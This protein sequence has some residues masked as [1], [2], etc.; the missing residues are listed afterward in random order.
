[1]CSDFASVVPVFSE[2]GSPVETDSRTPVEMGDKEHETEDRPHG[3]PTSDPQGEL[4]LQG[5]FTNF[6]S[7]LP[8]EKILVLSLQVFFLKV[9]SPLQFDRLIFYDPFL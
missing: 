1:M 4:S 9:F 5:V 8:K 7:P 3:K 2:G 6:S